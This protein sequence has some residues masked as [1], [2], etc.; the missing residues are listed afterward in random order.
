MILCSDV[1]VAFRAT[2]EHRA[3]CSN[4]HTKIR[5]YYSPFQVLSLT[6][7]MFLPFSICSIFSTLT[8]HLSLAAL[9]HFLFLRVMRL[10]RTSVIIETN[11]LANVQF[12]SLTTLSNANH[13][14]P[15]RIYYDNLILPLAAYCSF[16]LCEFFLSIS[17]LTMFIFWF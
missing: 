10:N 3:V 5:L 6:F 12:S 13:L 16:Q 8:L 15:V 11:H 14:N 9:L 7:E 17:P 4:T 1:V 2:D